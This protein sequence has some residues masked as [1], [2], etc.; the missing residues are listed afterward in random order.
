MTSALSSLQR[1]FVDLLEPEV[2]AQYAHHIKQGG[3]HKMSGSLRLDSNDKMGLFTLEALVLVD[4]EARVK[5][6]P[7]YTSRLN[8]N[9]CLFALDFVAKFEPDVVANY[10]ETLISSAMRNYTDTLDLLE[11]LTPVLA[12]YADR[13]VLMLSDKSSDVRLVAVQTLDKLDP[14]ALAGY[15]E[16]IIAKLD[17]D[18]EKVRVSALSVL[19]KADTEVVATHVGRVLSLLEDKSEYVRCETLDVLVRLEPEVIAKYAARLIAMLDDSDT[20]VKMKALRLLSMV[21]SQ[22]I[23]KWAERIIRALGDDEDVCREALRTLSELEPRELAK[24][25][26][27]I[28]PMLEMDHFLVRVETLKTLGKLE[29]KELAKYAENIAQKLGEENICVVTLETLAKLEPMVLSRYT[30]NIIPKLH[31]DDLMVRLEAL[32][33]LEK[34]PPMALMP[35]RA[36]LHREDNLQGQVAFLRGRMWLVRMRQLF[37]MSRLLWWWRGHSRGP[38]SNQAQA[39]AQEFRQIFQARGQKRAREGECGESR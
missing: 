32:T 27:R 33:T 26:E 39:D 19:Q 8:D 25:G 15:M 34:L 38:G 28:V 6:A 17:D 29:P 35:Y 37:W 24:Y 16:C 23:A 7:I 36:S 22:E 21:G 31:A 10:I 13:V 30:E 9:Q 2:L 11:R 18:S 4:S 20:D 1:V 12:K 3:R 14:G 5:L